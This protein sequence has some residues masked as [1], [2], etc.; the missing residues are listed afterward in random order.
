[1]AAVAGTLGGWMLDA[2]QWRILLVALAGWVNR[3][4]FEVIAVPTRNSISGRSA[5]AAS[6]FESRAGG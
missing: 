3:Q 2:I 5:N 6:R 4:Q 1:M